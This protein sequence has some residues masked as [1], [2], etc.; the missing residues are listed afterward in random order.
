MPFAKYYSYTSLHSYI[1]PHI[2]CETLNTISRFNW[3]LDVQEVLNYVMKVVKQSCEQSKHV[4]IL[5]D[6]YYKSWNLILNISEAFNLV[7]FSPY[8]CHVARLMT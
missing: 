2:K 5:I 6:V 8:E 7:H 3:F 4:Y 1:D